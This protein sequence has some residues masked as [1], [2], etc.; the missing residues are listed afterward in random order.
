M[1]IDRYIIIAEPVSYRMDLRG[2]NSRKWSLIC[3][4]DA[5]GQCQLVY[6]QNGLGVHLR[7][8]DNYPHIATLSFAASTLPDILAESP[9]S[10]KHIR[11][12]I[13]CWHQIPGEFWSIALAVPG[14]RAPFSQIQE[15]LRRKDLDGKPTLKK[16]SMMPFPNFRL[17]Q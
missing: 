7:H 5:Q 11:T 6:V 3:R 1:V 12:L 15:A 10:Q 14:T 4:K 2:K 13:N 17:A 8:C 9:L 16:A